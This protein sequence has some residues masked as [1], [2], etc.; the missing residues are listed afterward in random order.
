[1]LVRGPLSMQIEY[2]PAEADT[3]EADTPV[4]LGIAVRGSNGMPYEHSVGPLLPGISTYSADLQWCVDDPCSLTAFTFTQPV[5][6]ASSSARG[7]VEFTQVSDADGPVDLA[8]AGTAGWRSGAGS[9][10]F[11]IAAGAEVTD[12]DA[13]RLSVALNL[14]TGSDAGIEVAD[15]PARLPVLQGSDSEQR[16]SGAGVVSGLDGRFAPIEPVGSGVLPRLLRNGTLADLPYALAAMGRAPGQLDYQ[17][18]L[19][20]SAPSTVPAALEAQGL[21]ILSVES[22]EQRTAELDQGGVA[23][24]LRLFLIAALVALLLG[25]GTLL[26]NAYVV[27]RRR[28]YELAALRALGAPRSVLVRASRREQIVLAYT[29]VA[30]GAV[31]GL[32]AAAMAIPNLLGAS[33]AAGPPPWFGPAWIPVVALVAVV[34]VLL[35][36]V[37]DVGARRTARHATLD[38]LRQ[39]QE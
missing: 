9:I 3:P 16:R 23:L 20:A 2:A 1:V 6:L 36:V 12:A 37:A 4:L 27:I 35:A 10:A 17:V 31:C 21:G 7:T 22:I 5:G 30:I 33:T 28:A 29:G 25:A 24:A 14:D 34:V 13:E 11:P 32:F 15:H 26:A 19:S 18:W 38:L 8:P 39:V